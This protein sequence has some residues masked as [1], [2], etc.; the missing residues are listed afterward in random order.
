[1]INVEK[2]K[3]NI[4]KRNYRLKENKKLEVD[5]KVKKLLKEEIIEERIYNWNS[6]ILVI[7]KKLDES[8]KKKLRIVVD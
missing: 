1:M 3:E 7:N 2:R 5:K 4:N 8:G 6:K